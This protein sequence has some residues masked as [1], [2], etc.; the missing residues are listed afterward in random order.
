M[1]FSNCLLF[2]LLST[3]LFCA[4]SILLI[5]NFFFIILVC[6]ILIDAESLLNHFSVHTID[7][8]YLFSLN[9]KSSHIIYPRADTEYNIFMNRYLISLHILIFK[10][11]DLKLKYKF[12][13]IDVHRF[14]I[15]SGCREGSKSF[16]SILY[17]IK[18]IKNKIIF[19][20]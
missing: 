3:I 14:I 4:Y 19:L 6:L 2:V 12:Y 15:P 1:R 7:G 10:I 9:F 11:I 5:I 16:L 8:R 18:N 20:K 13:V 17:I